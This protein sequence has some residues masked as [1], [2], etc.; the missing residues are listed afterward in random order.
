MDQLNQLQ[1]A[2]VFFPLKPLLFLL[3]GL[4][5][6][7]L[8]F[9]RASMKVEI[10]AY[11]EIS[12]CAEDIFMLWVGPAARVIPDDA[13]TDTVNGVNRRALNLQRKSN[14]QSKHTW[15]GPKI[16]K[17]ARQLSKS[18]GHLIVLFVSIETYRDI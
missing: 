17:C 5:K 15:K 12:G 2:L 7:L 13:L 9:L 1:F 14:G 6:P 3:P 18:H 4:P 11:H 10:A 16:T 8:R